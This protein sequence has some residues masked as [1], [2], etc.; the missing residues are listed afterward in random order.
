MRAGEGG[1]G[2]PVQGRGREYPCLVQGGREG[3]KEV[4]KQIENITFQSHYGVGG[5][6]AQ[7]HVKT[8]FI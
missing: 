1:E 6:Y 5:N 4:D 2:R 8:C 7:Y 3:G